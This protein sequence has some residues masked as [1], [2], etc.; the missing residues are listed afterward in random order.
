MAREL[1]QVIQYPI[2]TDGEDL[3]ALAA[4]YCSSCRFAWH[5]KRL[6]GNDPALCKCPRCGLLGADYYDE[7][8]PLIATTLN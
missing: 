7:D 8:D 6:A 3:Y 2:L 4:L 5:H 1:E